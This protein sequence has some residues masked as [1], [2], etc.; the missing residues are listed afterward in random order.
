ML[1]IIHFI[2]FLL[3]LISLIGI[4]PYALAYTT[5]Y[6]PNNQ[7][8]FTRIPIACAIRPDDPS[9]SQGQMDLFMQTV[10]NDVS[11]WSSMLGSGSSKPQ[12]WSIKY[13]E[14]TSNQAY[15]SST[16]D[17]VIQLQPIPTSAISGLHNT[18]G[19][20]W[21]SPA[22]YRLVVAYYEHW[23]SCSPPTDYCPTGAFLTIPELENV[24]LHELGHSLGLGHYVASDSSVTNAWSWNTNDAPSIMI[25]FVTV[26]PQYQ[27]VR[28]MDIQQVHQLYNDQGFL[29]FVSS[30]TDPFDS[31]TASAYLENLDG[32]NVPAVSVS[33]Q[34]SPQY[35]TSG[36]KIEI[37][38]TD[39]NGNA[40]YDAWYP[41]T[42]TYNEN[43]VPQG[44]PPG[45]YTLSAI[46]GGM[47]GQT[48]FNFSPT[49]A[50]PLSGIQSP[51]A[52]SVIPIPLQESVLTYTDK[53]LYSA[54]DT[55][56]ITGTVSPV[57]QGL[58]SLQIHFPNG[59]LAQFQATPDS[60]GAFSKVIPNLSPNLPL[61]LYSIIA[62]YEGGYSVPITFSYNGA[63]S[64]SPT[65]RSITT[66]PS[67]NPTQT[68]QTSVPP[69]IINLINE[70]DDAA[71]LI[72]KMNGSI[73]ISQQS[74]ETVD[75]S[76]FQSQDAKKQMNSA[77]D[78][79]QNAKDKLEDMQN[80]LRGA[81]TMLQNPPDQA[82]QDASHIKSYLNSIHS[83]SNDIPNDLAS[84]STYF[85]EA[86]NTEQQFESEAGNQNKDKTCF[87]FWC[88]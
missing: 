67:T 28:A 7:P 46:Y 3:I 8:T 49:S 45:T 48:S 77:W 86:K 16:C 62:T 30:N 38:V 60:S 54:G 81:T 24:L 33:A 47:K 58:V 1:R 10:Q 73:S 34:I 72:G 71:N 88:S 27:G 23:V 41:T 78:M 29:A 21:Y 50:A 4:S 83:D 35:Y 53:T 36:E 61:G 32:V 5:G 37:T 55:L 13:V 57:Q 70:K 76:K 63:P 66:G 69:D 43:I 82:E 17:I 39:Q 42:G 26:N 85:N 2:V 22:G 75:P 12:D 74:L 9:I 79:L 56:A 31:L 14:L 52:P 15:D 87:L 59:K 65:S 18:L 68:T 11:G 6:Q 40:I 51:S 19:W 44:M 25:P 80:N 20:E 64:A 84:V